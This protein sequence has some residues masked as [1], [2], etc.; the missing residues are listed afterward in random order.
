MLDAHMI[1]AINTTLL[2]LLLNINTSLQPQL[3]SKINSDIT[4]CGEYFNE[5]THEIKCQVQ[6]IVQND[7]NG[8]KKKIATGIGSLAN[9][10]RESSEKMKAA[11]KKMGTNIKKKKNALNITT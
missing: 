1:H 10:P 9:G 5:L 3:Y 7:I 2:V 4:T 11:R 6:I 8:K